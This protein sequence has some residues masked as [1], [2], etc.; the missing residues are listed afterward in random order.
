M[1]DPWDAPQ[2]PTRGDTDQNLTYAGI[3]RVTSAW[4]EVEFELSSL[5]NQFVADESRDG[6]RIYGDGRI[7]VNRLG[8]LADEAKRF[9]IRHC[10]QAKEARFFDLARQAESFSARR[11]EVAHGIVFDITLVTFFRDNLSDKTTSPQWA[12]VAPY[13]AFRHHAANGMPQFAYA[14]S[15]L[16]YISRMMRRFF[17]DIRQFRETLHLP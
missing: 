4:E 7:F 10:S 1:V 16:D 12:V 13:Y 2:L 3:G 8:K 17:W 6:W 5:C 15:E 9:F 14:S 11:H